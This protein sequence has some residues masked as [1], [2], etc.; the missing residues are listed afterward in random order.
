M[1]SKN[2]VDNYLMEYYTLYQYDI[3]NIFHTLYLKKSIY[4]KLEKMEDYQIQNLI[5][6]FDSFLFYIDCNFFNGMGLRFVFENYDYMATP[7]FE[8]M[9]IIITLFREG[10][11]D[12]EKIINN[13]NLTNRNLIFQCNLSRI[14]NDKEIEKMRERIPLIPELIEFYEQVLS[15][16][17]YINL[18]KLTI[19]HLFDFK[20]DCFKVMKTVL[21]IDTLSEKKELLNIFKNSSISDKSLLFSNPFFQDYSFVNL[22]KGKTWKSIYKLL[23]ESVI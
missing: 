8:R 14:D 3:K 5:K 2:K 6:F 10:L 17:C 16:L 11:I 9:N 1:E 13:D 12:I 19:A 20:K 7:V 21:K 22:S 23:K 4:I 15:E 18:K